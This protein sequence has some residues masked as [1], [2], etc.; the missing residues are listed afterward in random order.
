MSSRRT[1]VVT[2]VLLVVMLAGTV[3]TL[4][5]LD[6]LRTK[7]GLQEVL[8][9]SSPKVLKRLSLGYQGLMADIYWTRA[10][11][12][13]G[14]KHRQGAEE[15]KLLAPLLEITTSLDPHLVVAYQFGANFLSAKPPNGAGMPERAVELVESGIRANPQEWRLYYNLGFIYYLEL[16]DYGKA[17]EAFDRGSKIPNAHPFLKVMAANMAQHAGETEMARMLWITT[18]ESTQDRQI[19]FNAVAHLRALRVDDDVSGLEKLVDQYRQKTGHW[20][21]SFAELIS[22][23][24]LEGIPA[25]PTGRA[26][27]LMPDG[28]IEVR[29]PEELPF[30]TKGVPPGYKPGVPNLSHLNPELPQ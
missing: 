1:T 24:M 26:Y 2:S 18:F 19:K 3:L 25:D 12:Y 15:Y 27:R 7:A 5:R 10:V 30:I 8:Y 6:R 28:H 20:P 23:D 11:Q 9:F 13:F 22:A 21:A 16:H 17:A 29:S 4:G 14:S